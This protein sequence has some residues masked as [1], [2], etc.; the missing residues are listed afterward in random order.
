M[1]SRRKDARSVGELGQ[2]KEAWNQEEEPSLGG[3][4]LE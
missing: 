2:M 1:V 3:E 4:I